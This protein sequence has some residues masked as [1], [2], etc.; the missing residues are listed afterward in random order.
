MNAR[1]SMHELRMENRE[2]VMARRSQR[3]VCDG[4]DSDRG[5]R[6]DKIARMGDE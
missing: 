5:L 3:Q 2:Q 4:S 6:S 1:D